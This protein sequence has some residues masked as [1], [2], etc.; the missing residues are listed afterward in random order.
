M[1]AL[2]VFRWLVVV[3]EDSRNCCCEL[4]WFAA[5]LSAVSGELVS[6]EG[7]VR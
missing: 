5:K 4:Y 3:E 7:D 1:R 6:A 2:C